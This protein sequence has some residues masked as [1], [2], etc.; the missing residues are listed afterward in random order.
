MSDFLYLIATK[1]RSGKPT[2]PIKVGV[3]SNLR[4]RLQMLQTGSPRPLAFYA[5]WDFSECDGCARY[6]E[7]AFLSCQ[8]KHRLSGEW[9]GLSPQEA[10][11][12]LD[13]YF[14]LSLVYSETCS[15]EQAQALGQTGRYADFDMFGRPLVRHDAS[16]TN[17]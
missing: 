11:Q 15:M 14:K 6:L 2:G 9:F 7:S 12:I 1:A 10:E 13:L 16:H 8:K 17:H 3:T 4:S 5:V